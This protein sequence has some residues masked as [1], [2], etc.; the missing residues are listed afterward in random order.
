MAGSPILGQRLGGLDS[1]PEIVVP[2]GVL[3]GRHCRGGGAFQHREGLA[4]AVAGFEARGLEHLQ[5]GGNR[6]CLAAGER[7]RGPLADGRRPTAEAGQEFLLAQLVIGAVAVLVAP[8]APVED[9]SLGGGGIEL[10]DDAR[11]FPPT[12]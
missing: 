6:G 11:S 3:Q 7:H 1:Q 5:Q 10:G 9:Q 8:A 12:R 4:G 2:E